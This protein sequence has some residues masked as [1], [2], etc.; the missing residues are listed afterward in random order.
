MNIR[1]TVIVSAARTAIGK[2]KRGGLA[3]VRPDELAAAVIVDLLKRTPGL[4]PTKVEDVI[5]G[6]AF[7]EGEQGLNF[8]RT[9]VL[10]AGFPE[11]VSGETVNRLF[12]STVEL[13]R[14]RAT[15]ARN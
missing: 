1:D 11:T 8:A 4:D 5:L 7:P 2:S 6:C 9:V 14:T 3:T 13:D 12:R 15:S 10:R